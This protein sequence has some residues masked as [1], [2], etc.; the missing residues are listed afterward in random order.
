MPAAGRFVRPQA[1]PPTGIRPAPVCGRVGWGAYLPR[2]GCYIGG[3]AGLAQLVERVICNH[4]A[5]GSI[6]ATGT[7]GS[8]PVRRGRF[9]GYAGRASDQPAARQFLLWPLRGFRGQWHVIQALVWAIPNAAWDLW[10]TGAHRCRTGGPDATVGVRCAISVLR[11]SRCFPCMSVVFVASASPAH[12]VTG[13]A[14]D[15][16][17]VPS[18]RCRRPPRR[19]APLP[20]GETGVWSERREPKCRR[21]D[22]APNREGF[23]G[24]RRGRHR[25]RR[26]FSGTAASAGRFPMPAASGRR[27]VST[28][29]R[30]DAL[31]LESDFEAQPGFTSNVDSAMP[32]RRG[33]RSARYVVTG[34]HCI[35]FGDHAPFHYFRF[36]TES[37][38]FRTQPR[39][40]ARGL[41]S[42]AANMICPPLRSGNPILC[43]RMR[44]RIDFFLRLVGQQCQSHNENFCSLPG[45]LIRP[46]EIDPWPPTRRERPVPTTPLT[47]H[48]KIDVH[49]IG[50]RCPGSSSGTTTVR[51]GPV[52]TMVL[53]VPPGA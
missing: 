21:E 3:R 24:A 2:D 39:N 33:S 28:G 8:M 51:F 6:P 14:G 40:H 17:R 42:P 16:G 22:C 52:Q 49:V 31:P 46:V 34:N 20:S 7:N 47:T 13:I 32:H 11:R 43:R 38:R 41:S 48:H 1:M 50:L 45:L 15:G 44:V 37:V 19:N 29:V 9:R 23:G 25:P 30:R 35:S 10:V 12:P 4:D 18:D 36:T 5:A 27:A 53:R 26:A